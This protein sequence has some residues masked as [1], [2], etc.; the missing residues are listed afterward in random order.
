MRKINITIRSLISQIPSSN[1]KKAKMVIYAVTTLYIAI[2][3]FKITEIQNNLLI[4]LLRNKFF[5]HI[6]NILF[7]SCLNFQCWDN[8]TV[9]IPKVP[10]KMLR[11]YFLETKFF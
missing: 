3:N 11:L 9:Y 2:S 6:P 5:N 1:L 10:S 4:F 8:I 7:Q